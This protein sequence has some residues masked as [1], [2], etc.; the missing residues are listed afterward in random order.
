MS[1]FDNVMTY[2][3]CK[4]MLIS[5][6]CRIEYGRS[7]FYDNCLITADD[8]NKINNKRSVYLHEHFEGIVF[9]V[10]TTSENLVNLMSHAAPAS[11]FISTNNCSSFILVLI[12]NKEIQEMS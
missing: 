8:E 7:S 11:P 10:V 2:Q 9:V 3:C 6:C 5:Y 4:M 12:F 1:L